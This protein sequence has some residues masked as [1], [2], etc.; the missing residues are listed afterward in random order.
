[1]KTILF[2][3]LLALAG[4]AGCGRPAPTPQPTIAPGDPGRGTTLFQQTLIGVKN[5]PGCINCHSLTPGATLVGPS[6]AGIS[7]RVETIIKRPSYQG[8]A[9]NGADYLRES[10]ISPNTYVEEGFQA[11]SMRAT[12][13]NELSPQ[14]IEDLVAYLLTLK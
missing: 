11:D 2:V 14:E 8:Q 10:I 12:Y 3:L 6:L 1:M 9:K 4:M 5:A 13:A 7:T